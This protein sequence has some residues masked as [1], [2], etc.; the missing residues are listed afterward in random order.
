MTLTPSTMLELGT[1]A[2][3]FSLK[4]ADGKDFSLADQQIDKGLL[5]IFMC[6]HCPYVIHIRQKLVACIAD[7]QQQGFT[8]VAVNSNDFDEYPADSP[9]KMLDDAKTYNYTFPYLVDEKQDVAKAYKA[10]CTPDLFLFDAHKKLVYRGQFDGAR[11]GNNVPVTGQDLTA[12]VENLLAGQS[13]S[14]VQRPSMGCNIKW[15]EG[16]APSYFG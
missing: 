16:N 8:V 15:K 7:Y 12:A 13:I 5:V 14:P 10:A 3:D 9:D 4:T 11:P 2:P 1:T 6:N